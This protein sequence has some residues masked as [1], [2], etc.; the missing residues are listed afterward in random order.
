MLTDAVVLRQI[1]Y[2]YDDLAGQH[3]ERV[4][5]LAEQIRHWRSQYIVSGTRANLVPPPGWRAPVDW[6]TYPV[7]I[8]QLQEQPA[9]GMLPDS[10]KA[11]M[12]RSLGSR[13]RLMYD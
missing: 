3:P 2:E 9:P 12:Q 11:M 1:F 8:T 6:A 5:A 13:G 7:P 4:E 10:S